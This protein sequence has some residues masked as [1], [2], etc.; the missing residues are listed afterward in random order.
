[1]T[2]GLEKLDP[3]KMIQPTDI[4]EAAMLAVR[5]SPHCVP[6]EITLRIA[7]DVEK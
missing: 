5:T 3:E 7:H 2:G 6:A 4:V 1:M